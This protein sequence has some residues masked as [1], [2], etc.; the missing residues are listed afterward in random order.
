[1][2]GRGFCPSTEDRCRHQVP[3]RGH[4]FQL[5]PIFHI[6]NPETHSK[7]KLQQLQPFQLWAPSYRMSRQNKITHLRI[8]R[9]FW[10]EEKR[11]E[12]RGRGLKDKEGEGR[13]KG[14]EDKYPLV[15]RSSLKTDSEQYHSIPSPNKNQWN[16]P[17]FTRTG[18]VDPHF[19]LLSTGR[20]PDMQSSRAR[21][22]K[23]APSDID[24]IFKSR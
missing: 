21:K 10:M 3:H 24:I 14:S 23:K 2:D 4:S 15:I 12:G 20:S 19:P 5:I 9:Y 6:T 8:K 16:S 7:A 22:R 13:L 18:T 11:F 1:M 17:L